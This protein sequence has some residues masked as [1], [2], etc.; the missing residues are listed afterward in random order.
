MLILNK[1]GRISISSV[2]D[3]MAV[4]YFSQQLLVREE[5]EFKRSN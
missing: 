4:V 3:Q 1:L 5:Q 2:L